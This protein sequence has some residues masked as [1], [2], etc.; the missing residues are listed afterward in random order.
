MTITQQVLRDHVAQ[1]IA[2]AR[3]DLARLHD[4]STVDGLAGVEAC[5]AEDGTTV[6]AVVRRFDLVSWTRGTVAFA[7]GLDPE[8]AAKWRRSFTRTVFLA[9]NPVN[10][11]DRFAFAHVDDIG[12][13]AW[14]APA[15][16]PVHA[17]LRRLLRTFSGSREVAPSGDV[18]IDLPGGGGGRRA[19]RVLYLAGS[20]TT[21]ERFMVHMNHLLVEAVLDGIVSPGDRLVVRRVPRLVGVPGPFDALR[22]D[23]DP[24]CPGRL[25]AVMGLTEE[26]ERA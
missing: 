16:G 11:V 8:R 13:T 25:R 10:L 18:L 3:P 6:V 15:P 7:A 12:S 26:G 22:V 19:R 5:V 17:P 21:V 20:G 4:L 1:R 24:V 14:T 9:G 2:T 23:I